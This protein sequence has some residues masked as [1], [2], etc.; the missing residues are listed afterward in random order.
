MKLPNLEI[1]IPVRNESQ[2]LKKLLQRIDLT[3]KRAQLS[4]R[5]IIVDDH[6]TDT[7]LKVI[8]ELKAKYPIEVI[9]KKGD[10]G[11][12]YSILQAI[13]IVQAKAVVLLDSDLQYPPEVIPA[14]YRE[15]NSGSNV[16]V[17]RR[18]FELLSFFRTMRSTL[19]RTLLGKL[20]YGFDYDALSGLKIVH[21]DILSRV[22]REYA[23]P[24]SLDLPLIDIALEMGSKITEVSVLF[25]KRDSR[26]SQR[27]IFKDAVRVAWS[28]IRYISKHRQP[29]Q[30]VSESDSMIGAGMYYH[31]RSYITHTTLDHASSAIETFSLAQK[32]F[33]ITLFFLITVGLYWYGFYAAMVI[34]AI[35]STIYFIDVFFNLFLIIKSLH[36]P[37]EIVIKREEID[38]LK[39]ESLPIYTILCPLYKEAHVL[40]FFL[41]SI[42]KLDWPRE[43]L[44]VQLLLEADDRE[45]ISVA[46]AMNLPRHIRVVVV[47]DS[48]PKTK[49]KACNYGLNHAKGEYVVIYDAEDMPDP[50]QL[51]KVYLAFQSVGDTVKCIQAK[52]N[53]YNPNQNLLTRFFTA[54]YSLWFDVILTGLQSIETTIPLGGTSNHFRKKDLLMFQGWDPFNVTEDCDLGVRLFS[55]GAKTAI[56]D[57]ITLEEA[58]SSW[59]N[60]LRQRSRWIK[61]Y[62]Q[63]YL[64]HMRH[65]WELMK[66]QGIHAFIFQLSVGGKLAF[67]LINPLMWMLTISYFLLYSVVGPTIDA[68]YPAPIFYMAVTSLVFGNFMFIY[69]YMIGVAKRAHWTVMKFVLLVPFYWLMTSWAALI[70]LYQL[71]VKPHYWEKTEHGLHLKLAKK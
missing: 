29:L 37:P 49:P 35:L 55:R 62:M 47:P 66:K 58:N 16:V 56:I 67:M 22:K 1:I 8:K 54:E 33:F 42:K 26:P 44:D 68:L 12:A 60:W 15:F 32:I 36:V 14:M 41:E 19:G 23:S 7:S 52:L 34:V 40:P 20:L 38:K 27:P 6:S 48:Q 53:Y 11:K 31:R 71:I 25:Q 30:I 4:Y 63:T 9:Q 50:D 45:T 17:T 3:L 61:G 57:S 59:R 39:D 28:A 64:L 46:K 13:E 65:P 69:Y 51:K 18:N 24:Q 70:A 2:V 10:L 5:C 43:K 21:K